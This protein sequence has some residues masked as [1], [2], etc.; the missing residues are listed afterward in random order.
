[1]L[2]NSEFIVMLNQSASDREQLAELLHIS[3][4]QLKFITNARAGNG[5]MRIGSALVPFY[6]QLSDKNSQIFKLMSTRPE[7]FTGRQE[8]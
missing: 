3:K 4:E 8:S 1:M 2:S 5:L 6:N 7:D